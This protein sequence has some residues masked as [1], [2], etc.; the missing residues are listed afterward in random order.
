MAR[1]EKADALYVSN[2]VNGVVTAAFAQADAA[3]QKQGLV[4]NDALPEFLSLKLNRA[5]PKPDDHDTYRFSNRHGVTV[6]SPL[7]GFS[8]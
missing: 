7:S 5:G 4:L 6:H 8:I 1:L 3:L 2:S